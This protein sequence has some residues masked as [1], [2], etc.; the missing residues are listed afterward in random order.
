MMSQSQAITFEQQPLFVFP[1]VDLEIPSQHNPTDVTHYWS[2]I[3]ESLFVGLVE[4][5][6]DEETKPALKEKGIISMLSE[7]R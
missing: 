6:S 4:K 1:Y 3:K 2:L 5:N 7:R